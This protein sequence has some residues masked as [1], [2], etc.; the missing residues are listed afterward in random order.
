[1]ALE[2]TKSSNKDIKRGKS[3]VNQE[4]LNTVQKLSVTNYS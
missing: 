2:N 1:M 3:Q 4:L